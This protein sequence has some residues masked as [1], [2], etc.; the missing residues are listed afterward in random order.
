MNPDVPLADE[1]KNHDSEALVYFSYL[2]VAQ[3]A[4]HLEHAEDRWLES[5][6]GFPS[7]G[8]LGGRATS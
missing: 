8:I 5:L 6:R 4:S 1:P 2:G 3:Q 7:D